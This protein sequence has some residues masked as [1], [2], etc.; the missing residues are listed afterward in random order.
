MSRFSALSVVALCAVQNTNCLPGELSTNVDDNVAMLQ[1][2]TSLSSNRAHSEVDE[3]GYHYHYHAV[4]HSPSHHHSM[5]NSHDVAVKD[6]DISVKH[7]AKI[8]HGIPHGMPSHLHHGLPHSHSRDAPQGKAERSEGMVSKVSADKVHH[9]LAGFHHKPSAK[10]T[11]VVTLDGAVAQD[12]NDGSSTEDEAK[13]ISAETKQNGELPR[14]EAEVDASIPVTHEADVDAAATTSDGAN[15]MVTGAEKSLQKTQQ[16]TLAT[17]ATMEKRGK[18]DSV[19]AGTEEDTTD[20]DEGEASNDESSTDIN[21]DA[22]AGARVTEDAS[23]LFDNGDQE[24]ISKIDVENSLDYE[25]SAEVSSSMDDSAGVLVATDVDADTGGQE[26]N[27]KADVQTSRVEDGNSADVSS[28]MDDN[29]AVLV[30]TNVEAAAIVT[31][32]VDAWAD[33]SKE[34]ISNSNVEESSVDDENSAKVSSAVDDN[35]PALVATDVEVG[36]TVTQDVDVWADESKESITNSDVQASSV[37]D[38]NSAEVSSA[39]DD[40]TPVLV[41]NN[42]ENG[43]IV[44]DIAND[45]NSAEIESRVEVGANS[46]ISATDALFVATNTDAIVKEYAHASVQEHKVT[47]DNLEFDSSAELEDIR[48]IARWSRGLEGGIEGSNIASAVTDEVDSGVDALAGATLVATRAE[49]AMTK[50]DSEFGS[51]AQLEDLRPI[52]RWS[53]TPGEG[54]IA[55]AVTDEVDS[56]VDA[57]ASAT[58]VAM[59]AEAA[60][61]KDDAEFGSGAKV[62]DARPI[63]QWSRGL[64]E[65]GVEGSSLASAVTDEVESGVDVAGATLMATRAEAAATVTQD[66]DFLLDAS[67]QESINTVDVDASSVDAEFDSSMDANAAVLDVADAEVDTTVTDASSVDDEDSENVDTSADITTHSEVDAEDDETISDPTVAAQLIFETVTT[68]EDGVEVGMAGN[69]EDDSSILAAVTKHDAMDMEV[70]KSNSERGNLAAKGTAAVE[71]AVTA[72]AHQ[73]RTVFDSG[74]DA[75]DDVTLGATDVE[76]DAA[77]G[78]DEENINNMDFEALDAANAA[79]VDS[80]VNAEAGATVTEDHALVDTGDQESIREVDVEK[81]TVDDENSAEPNSVTDDTAGMLVGIDVKVGDAQ[82]VDAWADASDDESIRDGDVEASGV[83]AEISDSDVKASGTDENFAEIDSSFDAQVE[84]DADVD[85]ADESS[86]DADADV[87]ANTVLMS[88]DADAIVAQGAD[89]G[90]SEVLEASSVENDA[91]AE[92]EDARVVDDEVD[93]AVLLDAD[94]SSDVDEDVNMALVTSDTEGSMEDESSADAD[95]DVNANTVLMSTDADAIVAQGADSSI[96]EVLEASSVE[97][98]ADALVVDDEVD[99][100]VFLD[101]DESSDVDED[102]NM[103]LVTSDTEGSMEDESSDADVNANTVLTSTDADAIVAQGADSSISKVLE[104]SSVEND[105]SAEVEDALVVDDEVDGAVLLDADESSDVD[106]DVN[107]ALVTSGTEGSVED[108]N[109]AEVDASDDAEVD[110]DA[111]DY[112]A[113]GICHE[114]R[115]PTVLN[116]QRSPIQDLGE[117]TTAVVFGCNGQYKMPQSDQENWFLMCDSDASDGWVCFDPTG[118]V[119]KCL[120]DGETCVLK[121]FA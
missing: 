9:G 87:N 54:V 62:E 103:A 7:R 116:A 82:D 44:S 45:E 29:V 71:S 32:D 66:A 118:G 24:S 10:S 74:V 30:A 5:P 13:G 65:G 75:E 6:S 8:P 83:D 68:N 59:R 63:S 22:E 102:V 16:A 33:G 114:S 73:D 49:A 93:G 80:G 121:A 57:E 106:E 27:S 14:V 108:K 58:L 61:T 86:A 76:V 112:T 110:A 78:Q 55:S 77:I 3:N 28:D 96:S 15:L 20:S 69:V 17:V 12:S 47:E 31:Q 95:A 4:H 41:A 23:A 64:G 88:T 105:A 91:S 36:A 111:G 67:D 39:V 48:P 26:R 94:E 18:V 89:S 25:N 72:D 107:M 79:Q 56:G 90:I 120:G 51:A 85:V 2:L 43:A 37:D 119:G 109:S 50:D 104:A 21:T 97:N 11:S 81:H 60:M 92:V 46:T 113:V 1:R 35:V 53:R 117:G 70:I 98:D 100:A 38:E 34:S 115:L 40:N 52:A 84:A 42:V 101:A 99:G 19:V